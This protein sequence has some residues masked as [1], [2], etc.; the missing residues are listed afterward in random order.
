MTEP[1]NL[2]LND[3]AT[4]GKPQWWLDFHR[5]LRPLLSPETLAGQAASKLQ[6]R[7]YD[8]LVVGKAVSPLFRG[9][10]T[11]CP[12]IERSLLV[13]PHR[14]ARDVRGMGTV[15]LAEH[16]I[17]GTGSFSAG[18]RV[19]TWLQEGVAE[20]S[21]LVGISGGTSAL[22]AHPAAGIDIATK[23]E[24]HQTLVASGRSIHQINTVR[25][26]LSSV[27]GGH[28]LR[29]AAAKYLHV[30]VFA[31]SD[32]PGD[33]LH[34]IGSGPF[35]P[36]PTTFAEALAI[37]RSIPGFPEAALH[38]LKTGSSGSIPETIKPGFIPTDRFSAT[39]LAGS[40]HAQQT[41]IH[42]LLQSGF[43]AHPLPFQLGGSP[44][45]WA[46]R[47]CAWLK[48]T[49]ARPQTWW[50]ASGETEVSI[51]PGI[52]PGHGGRASTLLLHLGLALRKLSLNADLAV[53]ATDGADGNSGFSGGFLEAKTLCS[54]SVA[55]EGQ[56]A[57]NA[58]DA[59]G[60]LKSQGAL[61][62]SAPGETNFGDLLLIRIR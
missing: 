7:S 17:P 1:S 19:I 21:L 54:S 13:L 43:D 62:P 23:R 36:D 45:T 35:S 58:F 18:E 48:T 24:C 22:L 3:P 42:L 59:A 57:L 12:R 46:S 29:I 5:T 25:R 16:P 44:A 52:I 53:I 10:R 11:G 4:A 30:H 20:R 6:P 32:V 40:N 38:H 47:L 37:A 61:F 41:A 34:E 50:V 51:P 9:I 26:H 56:L 14:S 55:Q 33:A 8:L 31:V 2:L 39:I 49:E 60:F 28:L 15:L 27:K